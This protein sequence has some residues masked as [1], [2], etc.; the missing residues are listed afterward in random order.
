MGGSLQVIASGFTGMNMVT[1]ISPAQEVL[2]NL[3]SKF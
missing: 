2:E 3:L 1:R